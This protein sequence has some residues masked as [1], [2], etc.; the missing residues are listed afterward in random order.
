[1]KFLSFVV[2]EM[3]GEF[4]GKTCQCRWAKVERNLRKI[5][6][7]TDCIY[8]NPLIIERIPRQILV[9]LFYR[10]LLTGSGE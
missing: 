10:A 4:R 2:P 9:S 7:I 1:M 8:A 6:S 3:L 5:R